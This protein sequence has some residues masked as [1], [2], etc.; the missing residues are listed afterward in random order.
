MYLLAEPPQFM[1]DPVLY[2]GSLDVGK[3]A[4]HPTIGLCHGVDLVVETPVDLPLR[5]EQLCPFA[6]S[7][8]YLRGVSHEFGPSCSVPWSGACAT[9]WW[10]TASSSWWSSC[11]AWWSSCAAWWSSCAAWWSSTSST[12]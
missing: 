1:C 2:L 8:E 9:S 6:L 3:E 5:K 7:V 10:S 11:A 12:S 4:Q